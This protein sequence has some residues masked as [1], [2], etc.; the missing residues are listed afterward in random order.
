MGIG[1]GIG[2]GDGNELGYGFGDMALG[3]EC[4]RRHGERRLGIYGDGIA[5]EQA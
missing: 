5:H 1:G 4:R 3:R 2:N